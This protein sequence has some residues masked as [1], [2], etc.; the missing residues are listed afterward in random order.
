LG[1]VAQTVDQSFLESNFK[2]G[3][4]VLEYFNST[5]GARKGLA[6]TALKTA[7][8]GYLTRRLVDV[9]QDAIISEEDCGTDAGINVQAVVEAGQVIVSLAQRVLGR[10]AAEDIMDPATKKVIVK[11]GALLEEKEVDAI[12]KAQ[13]QEV[14]IRSVLTCETR[15]G[16]CVS[17]YGRNLATGRMV[18][19]GEAVGV[20]AAQSIGEPGTQLTMRTFH[21]G[22]VAQTVDQSFLESNFNGKA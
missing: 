16:V 9:A 15:R 13:I 14:R 18:E 21:L 2:E 11:T 1:G 5:H 19:I 20:I 8:S 12:E 7:N 22:G 10:T 17:C 4:S 6:D 3:L